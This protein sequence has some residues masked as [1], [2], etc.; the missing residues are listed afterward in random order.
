MLK[1]GICDSVVLWL[2]FGVDGSSAG[3]GR[4]WWDF[5]VIHNQVACM[6]NSQWQETL[7][8]LRQIVKQ[9]TSC[10]GSSLRFTCSTY[11]MLVP[12][13]L[14]TGIHPGCLWSLKH[15]LYLNYSS[16]FPPVCG[17]AQAHVGSLQLSFHT[18]AC[19]SSLT[20]VCF[21]F[22]GRKEGWRE[23]LQICGWF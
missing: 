14:N 7:Y 19:W 20:C 6:L 23:R 5:R 4:L 11:S 21:R 17:C 15:R 2:P 18:W 8:L 1:M 13:P 10:F 3:K 9:T 22:D 12:T 16:E